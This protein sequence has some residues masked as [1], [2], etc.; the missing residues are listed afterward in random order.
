MHLVVVV[1]GVYNKAW[2]NGRLCNVNHRVQCREAVVRISIASFL[3]G[4][5]EEALEA[6]PEFV[7]SEHPS[8]YVPFL[9]EEYR[10]LRL[11]MSLCGE[12]LELLRIKS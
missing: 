11:S 3:F 10:K 2:S 5:K 9:S 7:D 4:P 12:A 8:L 6:P 1:V